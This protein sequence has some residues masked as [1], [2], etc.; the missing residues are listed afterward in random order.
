MATPLIHFNPAVFPDPYAFDPDR[1]I[2]NPSQKQSV[3]SFSYGSRQCLGIQ[4]AY[5]EIYLVT[6]TLWRRYGAGDAQGAAGRLALHDDSG[7]KDVEM[8]RDAF[9][10]YPYR[11][12]K[13][14]RIKIVK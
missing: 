12:S 1:F 13:G 6:A 2:R 7:L 8:V 4:L 11:Q 3:M 10:P 14:V 9:I 5:A